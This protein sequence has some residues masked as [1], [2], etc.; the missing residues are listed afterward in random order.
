MPLPTDKS[1]NSHS[2]VDTFILPVFLP[3]GDAYR[4]YVPCLKCLG[5]FGFGI[6]LD[7]GNT[8]FVICNEILQ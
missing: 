7:L 8:N 4:V 2:P 1:Y 6:F 3:E 5:H